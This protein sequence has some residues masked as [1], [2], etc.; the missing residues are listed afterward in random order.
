[1][2]A[3]FGRRSIAVKEP[4]LL[5][6]IGVGL[7]KAARPAL[8]VRCRSVSELSLPADARARDSGLLFC[9][10]WLL[11]LFTM[12]SI[13]IDGRSAVRSGWTLCHTAKSSETRVIFWQRS[14]RIEHQMAPDIV[15]KKGLLLQRRCIR[16]VVAADFKIQRP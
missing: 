10:C 11:D 15:V 4:I 5:V 16:V 8:R 12:F 3:P 1:M 14:A 7:V 13:C 2:L 9:V 6:L